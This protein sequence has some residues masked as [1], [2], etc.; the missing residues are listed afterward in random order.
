MEQATIADLSAAMAHGE[1]TSEAIT[2]HYLTRIERIDQAGP[3]INAVIELNPEALE[4]AK[5]LD[6]ERSHDQ[7]R[8]P[9]HGV[10]ILIKD[11]I[12]TRYPMHTTAGSIVLKDFRVRRDAHLVKRLRRSGAVILGKANLSE[13]ANFRGHRSVSGWSSLGGLTRNPHALDRTPCGSSSGSAAGVAADLC[14]AAVGTETDGSI[15]CPSHSCGVV[16]LKPTVGLISRRG[17]VPIAHSQDT[18][19]PIG[20]TVADVAIMLGVMAGT[21]PKDVATNMRPRPWIQDYSRFLVEDGLRGARLG[22]ARNLVGNDPR[23]TE[24]LESSLDL[25]RKAGAEIVDP[26]DL[27]NADALGDDEIAILLTEFKADMN[28]YLASLGSSAPVH[29]LED[30]ITFNRDHREQV[31]TYFGQELFIEALAKGS[32]KSKPYRQALARCQR[33][34]QKEGI[35]ALISSLKLDAIIM[36]SGGPAWLI[37][38]V[39]GDSYNSEVDRTGPAAVAGYPHITVPAGSIRGLPIGLSFFAGAWQE[40]TLLKLAYAFERLSQAR[41]PPQFRGSAVV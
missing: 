22:V 31:L 39:N 12:E 25:M 15:I 5:A 41:R 1:L 3:K 30:L 29:S 21:D 32:L 33:L 4:E 19:G 11:N 28:Q 34:A 2:R 27:P 24:I 16:G 35:D 40:A 13:W 10:P 26:A 20:R 6:K 17:I 38:L 18:A 9:L 7:I 36:P 8:G 14:A 23:V 37:D